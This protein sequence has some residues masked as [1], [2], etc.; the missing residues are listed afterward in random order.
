VSST[1]STSQGSITITPL[2]G[3][4]TVL[5]TPAATTLLGTGIYPYAL[6]ASPGTSAANLWVEGNMASQLAAVP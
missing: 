4:V 6:W 3:M 1:G 2:T 5:L